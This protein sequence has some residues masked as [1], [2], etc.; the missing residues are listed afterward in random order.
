MHMTLQQPAADTDSDEDDTEPGQERHV[1]FGRRFVRHQSDPIEPRQIEQRQANRDTNQNHDDT[2]NQ[3]RTWKSHQRPAEDRRDHD[4]VEDAEG[5]ESFRERDVTAD[6]DQHRARTDKCDPAPEPLR[7]NAGA[8]GQNETDADQKQ[9]AAD[10]KV[11]KAE[12]ET[13]MIEV[14]ADDMK[15]VEIERR[16]I[17]DH[18]ANRGSAQRVDGADSRQRLASGAGDGRGSRRRCG[19][20]CGGDMTAGF[21][22]RG[23]ARFAASGPTAVALSPAHRPGACHATRKPAESSADPNIDKA[24]VIALERSASSPARGFSRASTR[25]APVAARIS[26]P[27][28]SMSPATLDSAPLISPPLARPSRRMSPSAMRTSGRGPG[29]LAPCQRAMKPPSNNPRRIAKASARR[30]TMPAAAVTA[31]GAAV[32]RNN[33]SAGNAMANRRTAK[34]S[35]PRSN[36]ACDDAAAPLASV[37]LKR[38]RRS[39]R[40]SMCHCTGT[41]AAYG[42][43]INAP[44]PFQIVP[45]ASATRIRPPV[46]ESSCRSTS[47]AGASTATAAASM[48]AAAA[49]TSNDRMLSAQ[50]RTSFRRAPDPARPAL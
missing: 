46:S 26:V 11:A 31:A 22:S 29:R 28:I 40:V 34:S 3:R 32:A 45:T 35:E 5:D 37:P 15:P 17:D 49:T 12:P 39:G 25:A 18:H 23:A 8:R 16:V 6:R 19:R 24:L 44:E 7:G 20:G 33:A 43:R 38:E 42:K 13:V 47:V 36:V 14:G 30:S 4:A 50:T 1:I 21:A 10:D 27:A 2:D 9:E 41:R 48:Q